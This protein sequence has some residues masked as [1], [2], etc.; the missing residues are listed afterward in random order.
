MRGPDNSSQ[1]VFFSSRQSSKSGSGSI[2]EAL[3]LRKRLIVVAN[4][5]LMDNHQMELG[6]A[7]QEQNYLVCC[8]VNQLESALKGK[9]YESLQPFPEPDPSRF[10]TFLDNHLG[11]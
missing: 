11:F 7:L 3:R 2:L 8:T 6:S 4:E 1:N 5:D 9:D 10:A